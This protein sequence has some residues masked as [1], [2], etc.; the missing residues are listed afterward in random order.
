MFPEVMPIAGMVFVLLLFVITG[1][2]LPLSKRI[3]RLLDA[4]LDGQR[5]GSQL[6]ADELR[7]LRQVVSNGGSASPA[8]HTHD[9]WPARRG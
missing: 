1:G 2:V 9:S 7:E 4:R 3:G 6:P 8:S 5:P